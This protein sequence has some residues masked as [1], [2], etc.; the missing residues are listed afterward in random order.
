MLKAP[1]FILHLCLLVCLALYLPLIGADFVW[2]DIYLIDN[3]D[4]RER[5]FLEIWATNLWTGVNLEGQNISTQYYRP[6]VSLEFWLLRGHLQLGPAIFHLIGLLLHCATGIALWA[7]LPRRHFSALLIGLYWLHPIQ[8]ET[9]SF[10]AAHNDLWV[11]LM[12]VLAGLCWKREQ[13]LGAAVCTLIALLSKESG[14]LALC[15]L[16][17]DKWRDRMPPILVALAIYLALRLGFADI[18]NPETLI[19][20]ILAVL[21]AIGQ[22]GAMLLHLEPISVYHQPSTHWWPLAILLL[23]LTCLMPTWNRR[24]LWLGSMVIALPAALPL[25]NLSERHASLMLLSLVIGFGSE[26]RHRYW[27]ILVGICTT[28]SPLFASQNISRWMS[29]TALF[30]HAT[31]QSKD[32]YPARQLGLSL[33]KEKRWQESNQALL[34]AAER[35]DHY[36]ECD[37]RKVALYRMDWEL[38]RQN[39]PDVCITEE[40]LLLQATAFHRQNQPNLAISTLRSALA[41]EPS[42]E[43]SMH[44]LLLCPDCEVTAPDSSDPRW[45]IVR[46]HPLHYVQ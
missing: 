41:S 10:I 35:G 7:L 26:S 39:P 28:L 16:C 40:Q 17:S 1:Q 32:A 31:K 37:R 45:H 43:L 8:G 38:L 22:Y 6:W 2:D 14:I 23:T 3:I 19:P 27:V 25:G 33:A 18:N 42:V 46:K 24:A 44:I 30:E 4:A 21:G 29:T 15:W 5:S 11:L 13:T 9:V 20:N 36:A 34:L 12:I